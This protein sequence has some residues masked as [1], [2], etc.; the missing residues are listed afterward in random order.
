MKGLTGIPRRP[1]YGF[2]VFLYALPFEGS[3][4]KAWLLRRLG[5]R[6]G[7]HV[8]FGRRAFVLCRR[9]D[10]TSIGDYSS[11]GD[12]T[13]ITAR[14]LQ[15]GEDVRFDSDVRVR[16]RGVL[17]VGNGCYIGARSYID[18]NSDVSI[19]DDAG[20]GPG[21]WI[22]THSVWQS[23]LEGGSRAFAPVTIGRGAW[24]PANVFIMPGV[25]IG[26]DAV[27]GAR[28]LVT[29]DIAPGVLAAGSPAKVLRTAEQRLQERPNS[30]EQEELLIAILE[31][32][33]KVS[34]DLRLVDTVHQSVRDLVRV[35]E[36]RRRNR[37]VGRLA[38]CRGTLSSS[39]LS[40]IRATTWVTFGEVEASARP[41][42]DQV[43]WFDV[44][45]RIRS[46]HRDTFNR[47]LHEVFRGEFGVRFRIA[48]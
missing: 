28:S 36:F 31:E 23:V 7:R 5:A 13:L 15:T 33:A 44:R 12:R 14:A 17:R 2:L 20:V 4:L 37:I 45:G 48:K 24:I 26:E 29:S 34:L 30:E 1:A 40:A 10:Q 43:A 6:V 47:L 11:I 46:P 21:T 39:Q 22:F 3:R 16:G 9:F 35:Y 42:L 25:T 8:R 19:N 32:F 27:V 41:A 38:Y 18:V